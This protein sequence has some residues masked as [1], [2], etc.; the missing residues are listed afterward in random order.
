MLPSIV[1][2]LV[3][4]LLVGVQG[5]LCEKGSTQIEGNVYCQPVEAIRYSNVGASGTYNEVTK[6]GI[7]GT[8]ASTP[9]DFNGPLAPLDEEL[10][11]HFRGPVHLKQ[12]ATYQL[13]TTNRFKRDTLQEKKHKRHRHQI[14]HQARVNNPIVERQ[15]VVTAT[16]DG[17]V[18]SWINQYTG[19]PGGD[20]PKATNQIVTA[21]IDGVVQTWVNNWFGESTSASP[22][23]VSTAT[24]VAPQPKVPSSGPVVPI[25]QQNVVPTSSPKAPS[26]E[27]RVSSST[28]N[29]E[30]T[31]YY[32]AEEQTVDNLVFLGNYG[33]Q[34]SGVFDY[35]FGAS[36][37]YANRSGTGGASSPQILSDEIVPSDAE[38]IVM[39]DKKCKG[40]SCGYVRPGT[41]AHHG[42]DGSDKLFLM[43]F[44]MPSDG[45]SGFNA[46]MPAIWLLNAKIPRTLQYGKAECSCWESGCG[47]FDIVEALHSGSTYLKSTIHTNAP[48]GDSDY[49]LRPSSST[50]KL[51]VIF[52]SADSSIH[53]EMLPSG[54]EF[55]AQLSAGD[56]DKLCNS[57]AGRTVSRL[58]L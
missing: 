43:E 50:M 40:D 54:T 36:L 48:A 6:M 10:S 57:A 7:D 51:A 34:G 9:K 16:I 26:A 55:A 27:H 15:E 31:G 1:F 2:G 53:V 42:F 32:N 37:A 29:F 18:V 14:I 4:V 41:V 47:E 52:S 49:I 33:G 11:L 28:G 5:D 25:H 46:D 8:C 21:T 17:R 39:L 23:T 3:A 13:S 12:L 30:R 24:P 22:K 58:H 35:H 19:G 38:I 44:S 20:G 45:K 56:L